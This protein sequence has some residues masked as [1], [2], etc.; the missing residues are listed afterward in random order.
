MVAR[1]RARAH[2]VDAQHETASLE[3]GL[4]FRMGRAH[5]HLREAWERRIADTGLSAPQ[6]AM[7]R[8][9]CEQP[10]S[11]LREL[12]RRVRTDPMNVK[13]LADHLEGAGLVLSLSATSAPSHRQRRDLVPTGA[14]LKLAG[15]VEQRAAE[16]E[17]L[18]SRLLGAGELED[19]QRL[20]SRLEDVLAAQAG[21]VCSPKEPGRATTRVAYL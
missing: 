17:H 15:Q 2:Q 9:I 6:A 14:G 20:L 11:G 7:L 10:G 21:Q 1:G 12:A 16:W 18:L 19:L 8:A 13:R 4:G 5:R 3:A